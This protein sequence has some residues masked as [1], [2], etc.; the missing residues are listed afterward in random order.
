MTTSVALSPSPILQFFDNLGRP[1]VGGSVLTQVGGVNYPTYS[2]N[3]GATA[4]PNPIPLNSRGEVSTAAG[5][6]VSLFLQSGV[7]Y[8]FTL[9]DRDGNQLWSASNISSSTGNAVSMPTASGTASAII[10]TNNVPISFGLGVVQW[11]LPLSANTGAVTVNDDNTGAKA[12]LVRGEPLTGSELQPTIP[13]QIISDGTSW[14]LINPSRA[15][16]YGVGSGTNT[17]TATVPGMTAPANGMEALVKHANTSTGATTLKLNGGTTYNVYIDQAGLTQDPGGMT[18]Q[19]GIGRYVFNSSFNSAAG[20]WQLMN[21]E[22]AVSSFTGTS[23]GLTGTPTE[24]YN[25]IIKETVVY[26]MGSTNSGLSAI[27]SSTGFS[28]TGLPTALFPSTTRYMTI[29]ALDN[30]AGNV[31]RCSIDNLGAW[32]LYFGGSTSTTSWT[33]SGTKAFRGTTISYAK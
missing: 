13:A 17:I 20:G 19:N 31:S 8:T 7:S 29:T 15:P 24:T 30:S 3:T 27:S 25:Y 18:V 9:S 11:F 14:N 32:I 4:L 12:L 26:I 33:A 5:T 23:V 2:D 28:I 21:P 1:A 10:I 6:S 22:T 16:T